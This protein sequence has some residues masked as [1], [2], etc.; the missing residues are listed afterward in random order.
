M[1][2]PAGYDQ[3]QAFS[4]AKSLPP[5]GYICKIM[6]AEEGLT[7]NGY[8]KITLYFD[9][10]EGDFSGYYLEQYNRKKS[11]DPE[12]NWRGT[13]H[14]LTEGNSLPYF[15]SMI[16]S[17]E[18]SNPGF[19]WIWSDDESKTCKPLVGKLFGGIFG[20]EEFETND[21]SI[22][23]ATKIRFVRSV[24]DVRKGVEMPKVKTLNGEY[25]DADD[26]AEA[27]GIKSGNSFGGQVFPE[28]EI[29]F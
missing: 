21:G 23:L 10:A 24:D 27:H 5:G 18:K 17:I 26:Y 2:K 29:P 9:I 3:T 7:K 25:V 12:S 13:Y 16:E 4:G 15:K 19:T 22:K 8:Q 11:S 6:K 1:Q 28:E 14:Q 20:Q